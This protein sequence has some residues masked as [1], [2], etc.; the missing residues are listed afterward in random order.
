MV[1]VLATFRGGRVELSVPVG[2]PD[3]TPLEVVPL[4]SEAGSFVPDNRQ[5]ESYR[6]FIERLAGSF[7]EEPFE[8]PLHGE[9]ETREEW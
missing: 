5:A 3:G 7:G 2:W 9:T 4:R 8:R 1:G 6:Q